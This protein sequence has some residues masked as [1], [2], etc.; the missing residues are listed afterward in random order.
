MDILAGILAA[1]KQIWLFLPCE[2]KDQCLSW[3]EKYNKMH[4]CNNVNDL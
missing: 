2:G 4:G 1:L 3:K